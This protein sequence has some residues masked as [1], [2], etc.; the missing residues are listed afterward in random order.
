MLGF[1]FGFG[2]GFG[3]GLG[4]GT[5]YALADWTN[6]KFNAAM[7][8][9][10][11]SD[12][13]FAGDTGEKVKTILFWIKADS[14][15]EKI[16]DL[17]AGTHY[18]EVAAGTATT[19]GFIDPTIYIDA[20]TSTTPTL[21]TNWHFVAITTETAIT[22]NSVY[23][24]RVFITPDN[25]YFDGVLDD[26]KF[27]DRVLSAKEVAEHYRQDAPSLAQGG[28]IS[29]S[30]ANTA[31]TVIQSGAGKIIL[32]KGNRNLSYEMA[33]YSEGELE[34]RN[35]LFSDM[36][37]IDIAG[38]YNGSSWTTTTDEINSYQGTATTLLAD[39][40]DFF[41]WGC[42][43]V[44]GF[45]RLYFDLNAVA[46]TTLAL[47]WEYSTGAQTFSRLQGTTTTD[48]VADGFES[49]GNIDWTIPGDWAAT[50]SFGGIATSTDSHYLVRVSTDTTGWTTAPTAYF[51]ALSRFG[52]DFAR[53][54]T[55]GTDK[56]RI[57]SEG[58]I[59]VAGKIGVATAN[60]S[61]SAHIISTSEQLR[62]AHDTT[63]YTQFFTDA[64]GD[65]RILSTG[66]DIK[67]LDSNLWICSGSGGIE[68]SG[69]PSITLDAN[70]G[71]LVVENNIYIDNSDT[72]YVNYKKICPTG[73]IWVDGSAEHGTLPGFCVMKVEARSDGGTD[74]GGGACPTAATSS[75]PWVS[76]SQNDAKTKCRQLGVGY[77]LITDQ[78]WMTIAEDAANFVDSNW[79]G[80]AVGSGNLARG[81][82]AHT[83]Y[84]DIWINSAVA[85]STNAECLYNVE[86]DMCGS[87]GAHLYRRTLTL[88]NGETIWDMSGNVYEWTDAYI[89]D[90]DGTHEMPLPNIAIA[91]D[92]YEYASTTDNPAT[93]FDYVT[94]YKGLN[95]I[96]PDHRWDS[97][98]GIGRIYLDADCAGTCG[99]DDHNYHAFIR[100]G[101]WSAGAGAGVFT[102]ALGNA[103]SHVDHSIGFRCAR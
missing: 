52:S 58:D 7:D 70:G 96:R 3:N 92:W 66:E 79:S 32:A 64:A 75:A 63:N 100:G 74:C 102:L 4:L 57:D 80:A 49:D 11:T 25:Y 22:A 39:T 55:D 21:D 1:G 26:V 29:D 34:L 62:L 27:Y 89:V 86:D 71:S 76:I 8:F 59:Y 98:Q 103:P 13:I 61:T 99:V 46:T 33:L 37:F 47:D 15:T 20:A 42:A 38:Y 56:F 54:T 78:E 73:Y 17:D 18:I 51:A 35:T 94:D 83:S 44:D 45:S 97:T 72:N 43:S 81:W 101:N 93:G 65:L 84:G 87:S 36:K 2:F 12:F 6:G 82:A 60:A 67:M 50:A 41:Y 40:D 23:L 77:H 91:S 88:S 14:T 30:S 16:I 68:S 5:Q 9:N 95:Y 19:T 24:G 90:D 10:G 85:T 53:F 69:C 48:D 28:T 31:L